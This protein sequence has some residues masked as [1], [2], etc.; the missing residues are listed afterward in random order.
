MKP[1]KWHSLLTVFLLGAALS[2]C[3]GG[4]SSG[5]ISL[6][7]SLGSPAGQT[8]QSSSGV[9]LEAPISGELPQD[10]LLVHF[11]D[12]GQGDSILIEQGEHAMLVD[13]G[14]NDQGKVVV[15][16]LENRGISR[17]DYVIGTHPHSDHIGGL[18][19]VI[20]TFEAERVFLPPVE[21]T[22]ATFEDVLT[23]VEG[24]GLSLTMPEVGEVWTLGNASFTILAPN[25]DYGNDLNN[26]SIGIRLEYGD[27]HFVL[28]GDA[29]AQAEEDI[30][31]NGL[32]LSADV[33]KAGH[34]GSSTS[35]C[36]VFLDQVNP[37][38]A[39]IQCGQDNSYGHPHRETL[40]KF[41]ERGIKV[42]RTDL[43]GTIV[44]ASDG[45]EIRWY[46]GDGAIVGAADSGAVQNRSYILNT[47]TKKFHL[48]DCASV[49]R[50][51]EDNRKEYNGSRK[52]LLEEGYSPCG[53]CKP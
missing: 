3:G 14:E 47:N 41:Q 53:Q 31:E 39:V 11:I 34:H 8:G 28:C 43:E 44:A 5:R 35:S 19:D 27:N 15:S 26:W 30:C 48:P 17:L 9:L 12:V 37:S 2:G 24:R 52:E 40:E 38:W 36:D 4:A 32:E 7:P 1:L 25:G 10:G 22:T 49:S 46:A 13:A 20:N 6:P 50:I 21:H 18:D 29:E 51:Q 23:A 16:Y 45:E 33:L 42:L